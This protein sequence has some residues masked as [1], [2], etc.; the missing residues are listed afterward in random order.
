MRDI[1]SEGVRDPPLSN[2][3]RDVLSE[4][5]RDISN[6]VRDPLSNGVRDILSAGCLPPVLG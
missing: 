1:F 2:G 4:G 6:G 3:L 5:V